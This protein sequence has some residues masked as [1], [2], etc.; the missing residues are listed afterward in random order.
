MKR[1]ISSNSVYYTFTHYDRSIFQEFMTGDFSTI[2]VDSQLKV[3]LAELWF[4]CY[5]K[6]VF[7]SV[8]NYIGCIR[9]LLNIKDVDINIG[10][11][12]ATLYA[13]L[14]EAPGMKDSARM[15]FCEAVIQ[16]QES[17]LLK[18]AEQMLLKVTNQDERWEHCKQLLEDSGYS[19]EPIGADDSKE[20][21]VF[22]SPEKNNSQAG[23]PIPVEK[24]VDTHQ[25]EL[26]FQ[27]R[28]KHNPILFAGLS[29]N[30]EKEN[31]NTINKT[32]RT[33]AFI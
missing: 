10:E 16:N 8:Q 27:K 33:T 19:T 20:E 4:F 13:R 17:D 31:D 24:K 3:G 7:D 28:R 30:S 32:D 12:V 29:S 15:D 25:S 9:K 5:E 11:Q 6:R 1:P 2:K 23:Y 18:I 14:A 26:P 21:Q 22:R